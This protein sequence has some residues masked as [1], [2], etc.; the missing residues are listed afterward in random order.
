MSKKLT[1]EVVKEKI[2]QVHGDEI[3]LDESTYKNMNI[4]ARFVDKIHG[5]WW[6]CPRNIIYYYTGHPNRTLEKTKQTNLKRYG[7]ENPMQNK[8]IKEKFK[9]TNLK[10]YGVE[11]SL[12]NKDI[13]EKT[14]QTNLKRYGVENPMQNKEIKE[15]GKQTVMKNF[16]VE[17]L[18]QNK[19]IMAK[20]KET[21]MKNFGV[22]NPFQNKEIK[23]K[24][25]QTN[26][27]NYGVE[28]PMQNP[29]VALKC[30]KAQKNSYVLTHWKTGEEI[31][32]V[33]GYEKK[34]IEYL[35]KNKINY[36]WQ[37]KVF[38]MIL[39]SGRKT[40]YRPDMYI[41]G[42]RNP[43]IEIKGYFRDNAKEKWDIF[44]TQTKPNSEL[45]DKDKLKEMN[46]L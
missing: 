41:M 31:V 19:K 35:N 46:I 12:Q 18:L 21:I 15:K 36:K 33:A 27:E 43:W 4:K 7:V 22:G 6:T 34:T 26:L 1:I 24:I 37:H 25:I 32:C 3:T 42:K 10:R 2:R 16:G 38:P 40:T 28:H 13:K 30:A 17:Y 14:K 45:W 44:H 29:R 20:Y 8:E 23:E 39:S 9:Q 5:E 11:C